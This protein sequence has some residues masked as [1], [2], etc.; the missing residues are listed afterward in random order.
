MTP[1]HANPTDTPAP[2]GMLYELEQLLRR[3]RVL[4]VTA[5]I[6]LLTGFGAGEATRAILRLQEP[7]ADVTN[8]SEGRVTLDALSSQMNAMR[9]MRIKG[10]HTV[11]A[12]EKYRQDVQPVE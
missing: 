7:A 3:L 1:R 11:D 2:R 12:V 6:L 10:E 4:L 5:P 8:P 9:A